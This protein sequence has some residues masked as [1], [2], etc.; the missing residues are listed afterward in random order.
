M[1]G[2]RMCIIALSAA[3]AII[4]SASATAGRLDG[5]WSMVAETTRGH[6][7]V[8]A[9]G[10]AISGSR[11]SSTGGSF[12]FYPIRL[13]GRV[14]G[15]GRAR[16]KAIAGPRI[17]HGSGRFS[18]LHGSGT[19]SGRGPSGLCSGVWSANRS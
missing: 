17:A 18:Y 16:M 9:V 5:N 13:G 4:G 2:N 10:L 3:S 12:A 8:I 14:S 6:C 15:S 19:W 7:G 11:I 1:F